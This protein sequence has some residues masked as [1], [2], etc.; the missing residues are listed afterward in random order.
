MNLDIS[1]IIP[2]YNEEKTLLYTLNQVLL[3][4]CSPRE[5]I[6]VNSS[7]TDYSSQIIDKFIQEHSHSSIK[8]YNVFDHT[9]SPSSSKNAGIKRATSEFVA[10]MDCGLLFPHDWLEKQWKYMQTHHVDFVSGVIRCRGVGAID[11]AAVTQ[12][13]GFNRKVVVVP[14]TIIKKSIITENDLFFSHRRAGYDVEWPRK[15]KVRGI[16]RGENTELV[17]QYNGTN[18]G[19]TLNFIFKKSI[20]YSKA[21]VGLEHYH[22]PYVYIGLPIFLVMIM[23]FIPSTL[24]VL[25]LIYFS[26]RQIIIPIKK[27]A[28]IDFVQEDFNSL[29]LLFPV[30]LLL[31]LG[32]VIGSY[33][34]LFLFLWH[35]NRDAGL[36]INRIDQ[37]KV[38]LRSKNLLPAKIDIVLKL[39]QSIGDVYLLVDKN[40]VNAS[41][42]LKKIYSFVAAFKEKSVVAFIFMDVS[43]A[44][45]LFILILR[46]TRIPSIYLPS[47][48]D[49][50]FLFVIMNNTVNLSWSENDLISAKKIELYAREV[51][52][53]RFKEI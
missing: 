1:V 38:I 10:F 25:F 37:N 53:I 50:G 12:T 48:N 4:S 22:A 43:I 46:I 45:I 23:L 51:I 6:F 44:N 29:L 28:G 15:L 21:C 3:Q 5:I 52:K 39:S 34:G 26:L 16:K 33:E 35:Q 11:I 18:F 17:I 42:Y 19:S 49:R 47:E 2:Y 31:D 14:S 24:P 41:V 20:L 13:Y 27:S 30:G 7:S 36:A 40:Q 9:N 8:I 32:K